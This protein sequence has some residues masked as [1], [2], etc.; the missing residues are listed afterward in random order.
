MHRRGN[1]RE[2]ICNISDVDG[3]RG[4]SESR[5]HPKVG[6]SEAE[7][8]VSSPRRRLPPGGTG[9]WATEVMRYSAFP[10]P[11]ASL[12]VWPG[13]KP[14]TWFLDQVRETGQNEKKDSR[15]CRVLCPSWHRFRNISIRKRKWKAPIDVFYLTPSPGPRKVNIAHSCPED[16]FQSEMNSPPK[17]FTPSFPCTCLWS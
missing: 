1:R 9:F 4:I 2:E 8:K 15:L 5:H 3:W 10:C 7:H 16:N 17:M 14:V 11:S 13:G 6:G 12:L